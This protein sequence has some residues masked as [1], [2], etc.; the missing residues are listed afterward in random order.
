MIGLMDIDRPR[1][2]DS[3]SADANVVAEHG[4]VTLCHWNRSGFGALVEAGADPAIR[5]WMP[6]MPFPYGPAEANSFLSHARQWWLDGSRYELAVTVDGS[7]AGLC[8]FAIEDADLRTGDVGYWIL[9]RHR[10]EGLAVASL[11]LM[12]RWAFEAGVVDRLVCRISPTNAASRLT[13]E[14]AGYRMERSAIVHG[15]RV[16]LFVAERDDAPRAVLVSPR[17]RQ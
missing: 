7:V 13:A 5:R 14:R 10:G 4:V 8:G 2:T 15:R 11:R 16:L 17:K 9:E 6:R 12:T 1:D 3:V